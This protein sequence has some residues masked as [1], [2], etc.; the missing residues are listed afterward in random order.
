MRLP[1]TLQVSGNAPRRGAEEKVAAH[2][3]RW[4][5][6]ARRGP[7]MAVP[8]LRESQKTASPP[9]R[10][11]PAVRLGH[12]HVVE[13]GLPLAIPCRVIAPPSSNDDPAAIGST[14]RPGPSSACPSTRGGRAMRS[15]CAPSSW[16]NE[17]IVS[18][19]ANE[20]ASSSRSDI[21][22]SRSQ[23]AA[24]TVATNSSSPFA[25]R[26]QLCARIEGGNSRTAL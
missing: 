1:F 11:A 16:R 22:P 9:P 21:S 14:V 24:R 13:L 4:I 8:P 10:G 25:T 20:R 2:A 17:G 6:L 18:E 19:T 7:G 23:P 15:V 5:A 26:A 3:S 12:E